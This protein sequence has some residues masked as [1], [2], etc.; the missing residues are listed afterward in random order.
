MLIFII[1]FL[2]PSALAL[3]CSKYYGDNRDLCKE[4]NPL[5]ITEKEKKQLMKDNV[6]GDVNIIDLPDDFSMN[7]ENQH[8]ITASELYD[9]KIHI[10]F[11]MFLLVLLIYTAY[12]ILNSSKFRKWLHADS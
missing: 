8:K 11:K 2:T 1:L 4:I 3:N 7:L 9:F 12:R 5:D 10:I 6:Y